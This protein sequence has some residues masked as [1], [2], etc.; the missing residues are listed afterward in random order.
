[1][2]SLFYG[3]SIPHFLARLDPGRA[4][5]FLYL[6]LV[7]TVFA[8]LVQ[9]W[10]VRRT[11]PSRVS[12]LLGTEP[13]WAALVGITIARD[14]VALAGYVGIA[15]ILAGTAWGR[16]IEERS[17]LTPALESSVPVTNAPH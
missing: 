17:R 7:C 16:S 2:A 9:T 3:D 14:P 15:L 8:F 12:L 1:M 4:A 10:A 5:L 6:V 11:S 13:V